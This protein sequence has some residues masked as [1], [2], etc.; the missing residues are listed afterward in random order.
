MRP[1]KVHSTYA[2]INLPILIATPTV[3]C[4]SPNRKYA[5]FLR[6][7]SAAIASGVPNRHLGAGGTRTTWRDH[8]RRCRIIPVST[9]T[10]LPSPKHKFA[11]RRPHRESSYCIKP[12]RSP[13]PPC[14]SAQFVSPLCR[15]HIGAG[16]YPVA[17]AC[18][19]TRFAKCGCCTF[20]HNSAIGWKASYQWLSCSRSTEVARTL[21][22]D[23]RIF[24][25]VC[26][27]VCVFV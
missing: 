8:H 14:C 2:G 17:P 4:T 12:R 9:T 3:F 6:P 20:L 22:R 26:V 1:C 18:M 23:D 16:I 24:M 5:R 10:S 21:C 25:C 13:C 19:C 27:C 11:G 15:P 7:S